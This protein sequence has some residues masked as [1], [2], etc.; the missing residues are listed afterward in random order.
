[1]KTSIHLD[2]IATN[3]HERQ[4]G[5]S[6]SLYAFFARVVLIRAV[7][8]VLRPAPFDAHFDQCL[9]DCVRVNLMVRPPL[10]MA[11]FRQHFQR[12]QTAFVALLARR[13]ADEFPQALSG[14][15]SVGSLI[16]MPGS[17]LQSQTTDPFFIE[18]VQ[19]FPNLLIALP[20]ALTDFLGRLALICAHQDDL[21]APDGDT[22]RRFQ[23]A[24]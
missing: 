15:I 18:A 11:D 13:L 21:A 10:L 2:Q 5:P 12:P 9:A 22:Y 7:D 14:F 20:N 1:V 3:H 19:H 4:L 23:P 24:F 17:R 16:I 6:A 8:P